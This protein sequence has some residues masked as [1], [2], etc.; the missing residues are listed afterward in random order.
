MVTIPITDDTTVEDVEAFLGRLSLVT[1]GVSVQLSP[2]ETEIVITDD[3][4]KLMAYSSFVVNFD[5]YNKIYF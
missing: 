3:D 2:Q 1:T 5:L 4:G